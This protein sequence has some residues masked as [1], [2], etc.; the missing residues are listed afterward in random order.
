M[1]PYARYEM[2]VQYRGVKAE[3]HA[4]RNAVGIFDVSHMGEFIVRGK[5]AV[6]LVQ[7]ATSNDLSKLRPGKVQ[8]TCLPNR[9]NGIVD[10]LLVYMISEEEYLLV[11]NAA[12]MGKDWNWLNELNEIFHADLEDISWQTSLLAIQ[13]PKSVQ[14]IQSLT[15]MDLASMKYFTFQKGRFAGFDDILISATGYTGSGGFEIYC[16]NE[17]AGPI[18]DAILEA[19]AECEIQP[20]GLA[21]RDT[22]RLEMGFFLYGNEINE[23]TS[24]NEA[25]LGWI[26]K[27][28]QVFVNCEEL[29][30][31][32]E[33]G[34]SK[35]L[36]GF[37]MVDKGIPRRDYQIVDENGESIGVVTSGTMSPTLNKAIGMGYIDTPLDEDMPEFYIQIRNKRVKA[38]KTELPF[39][40]G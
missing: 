14:A 8:Y 10:D 32:K 12:N 35:K 6:N 27:Y 23:H 11:V 20:C 19:G 17:Q 30:I 36:I 38:R 3:H 5:K 25:G 1:V 21:A 28:T 26:T 9:Q 37:E 39:Y 16:S 34:P 7:F 2:P 33:N 31:E 15:D 18:W 4:V 24:P 40:K 29:L 22:L 13:G